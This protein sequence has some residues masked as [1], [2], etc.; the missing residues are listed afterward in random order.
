[1]PLGA[2][3]KATS[4]WNGFIE[5]MEYRLAGWKKLYLSK[6]GW[7]TL[8]KSTLSD[9]PTYYLSLFLI[10]VGVANRIE[11]LQ[12][13]FLWGC[14]GDEV[15]FHLVNWKRICTPIELGGSGVPNLIQFN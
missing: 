13:D 5:N 6:G 7:L 1:L 8:I 14:I 4:I 3:Y 10:L 2:S 12:T 9:L 15:K 11:R